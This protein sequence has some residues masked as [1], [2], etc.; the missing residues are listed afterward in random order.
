MW[1]VRP[2]TRWRRCRKRNYGIMDFKAA[3]ARLNTKTIPE[4]MVG[5]LRE[6][7]MEARIRAHEIAMDRT[8][9]MARDLERR[10]QRNEQMGMGGIGVM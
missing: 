9:R 6:L 10:R 1:R 2:V 5:R 3:Q 7:A 4:W 8:K